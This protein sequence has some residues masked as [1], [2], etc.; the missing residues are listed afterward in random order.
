M[1]GEGVADYGIGENDWGESAVA[2]WNF[3]SSFNS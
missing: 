1:K 2:E 3:D